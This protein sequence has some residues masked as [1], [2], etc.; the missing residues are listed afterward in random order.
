MLMGEL[1]ARYAIPAGRMPFPIPAIV[2]LCVPQRCSNPIQIS[3]VLGD[4]S[5]LAPCKIREKIDIEEQKSM[6]G[7]NCTILFVRL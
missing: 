3:A 5:L 1:S 6:L 2:C 7:I 4:V